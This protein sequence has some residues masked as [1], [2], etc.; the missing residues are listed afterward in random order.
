V[1]TKQVSD[2]YLAGLRKDAVSYI[3]AGERDLDLGLALEILNRELGIK[4]L[5]VEGG[6]GANGSFLRAGLIDEIS[7]VICPAVDGAKG[8]PSVF[9]SSDQDAGAPAP[10][11]SMTLES[12]QVL[13]GGAV[14]LRYRLQ[15]G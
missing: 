7:L 9:D 13:E 2:A 1:L 3:F 15:S 10:V 11:R 14:W 12:S 5:L 6:G 8:A 4:R